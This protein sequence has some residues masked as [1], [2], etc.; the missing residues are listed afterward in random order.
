MNV[1]KPALF[2]F[3]LEMSKYIYQKKTLNSLNMFSI[4]I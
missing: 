4:L 3:G 1:E 2:H